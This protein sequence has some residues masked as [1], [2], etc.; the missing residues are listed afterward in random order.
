M[1]KPP[2]YSLPTQVGKISALE[3]SHIFDLARPHDIL[4]YVRLAF[5]PGFDSKFEDMKEIYPSLLHKAT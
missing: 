2:F 3:L 4:H 5:F 1:A